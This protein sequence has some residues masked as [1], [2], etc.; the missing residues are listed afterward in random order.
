MMEKIKYN[1]E[2]DNKYLSIEIYED[3]GNQGYRK[4][5][6]NIKILEKEIMWEINNKHYLS[7]KAF[8]YLEKVYKLLA[9]E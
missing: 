1:F 6:L 2:F 9:F 5:T 8:N 3:Y 4:Y 7:S